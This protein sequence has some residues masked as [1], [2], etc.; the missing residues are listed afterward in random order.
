MLGRGPPEALAFP[1]SSCDDLSS[2][3]S[4]SEALGVRTRTYEFVSPQNHLHP[5]YRNHSPGPSPV[6]APH[7]MNMA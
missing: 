6:R 2:Q 7:L 5:K 3:R 4:Q 1:D